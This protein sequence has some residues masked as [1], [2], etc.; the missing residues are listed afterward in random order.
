M[1][2]NGNGSNQNPWGDDK[3]D[4][5]IKKPDF[6]FKLPGVSF[7][8]LIV[9]AAYFG[10]GFFIVAP[11]EEAVVKRFGAVNRVVG[12]GPHYHLPYPTE[13]VD[14]AV[15]TK[16]HRIEIGFRSGAAGGTQSLPKEALMLTGD[17]NIVSIDLSLQYKINDIED[18]LYNVNNVETTIKD[19]AESAIREVAGRE[20]IDDILTIGK[21]RIQNETQ[22]ILQDML[23]FYGAGVTIVA[24]QLQ[25]VEPPQEVVAAFKDVASA[26]EDKNRYINE[27]EAY[28]NE[29]IPRAR[30]TAEAMIQ[31]A[32]GYR[33]QKVEEANGDTSRFNQI[34]ASYSKAPAITKKRLYLETMEKVMG[35]NNKYIFDAGIDNLSPFMGL[36]NIK[37]GK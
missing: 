16:V 37:G 10:S 30:G 12:S 6:N 19:A 7:L 27:A 17:E 22:R 25:D 4:F 9:I 21:N 3:F 11:D 1:N 14:K 8:G 20:M 24:V 23:D 13:T 5:K 33:K 2:S 35:N 28:Q 29:V 32:E 36:E 31:Q 26:R 34:L 15:V 18:F